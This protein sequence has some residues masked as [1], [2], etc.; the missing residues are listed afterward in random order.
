VRGVWGRG[1][2]ETPGEEGSNLE[3]REQSTWARK[4]KRPVFRTTRYGE[5]T[6]K[7]D[8]GRRKKNHLQVI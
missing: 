1:L 7:A 5:D 4:K 2:G 3:L 8:G 6:P